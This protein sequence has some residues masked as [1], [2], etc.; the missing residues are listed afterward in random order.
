VLRIVKIEMAEAS[1]K[2]DLSTIK[3]M[4]QNKYM[5]I[6][7]WIYFITDKTIYCILHTSV[8]YSL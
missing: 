1:D 8:S 6:L 3:N 4:N 5:F 7:K 2:Y